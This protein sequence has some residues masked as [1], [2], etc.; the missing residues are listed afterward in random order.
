MG[1]TRPGG[2]SRRWS[3]REGLGHGP[4]YR[5]RLGVE[6]AGDQRSGHC[7]GRQASDPAR[8]KLLGRSRLGLGPPQSAQVVQHHVEAQTGDE[9]HHEIMVPVLPTYAEDRHDVGV[10]QPGRGP[11]LALE[12][13]HL[14]GVQ[15]RTG[16][17]ELQG[18]GRPSDSCSAW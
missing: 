3:P 7:V 9:L 6:P 13:T 10:V 1:P 17:E 5:R 14:L 12:P 2:C 11:G 8:R 15:Q 18:H 16:R 4:D